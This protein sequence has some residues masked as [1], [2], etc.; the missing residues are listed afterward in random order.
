MGSAMSCP[1]ACSKVAPASGPWFLKI[2]MYL[3]R[4]S[5]FRSTMRSRY[6]QRTSSMR[7]S[8]RLASVA[9][10]SGVSMMTSCAP[11]P[12]I[13]S[14]MPS[15]CRL[16][17]PSIPSAGNLFGTTRTVQPCESREA[18]LGRYASTSEGVLFSL[19]GQ[20]GQ[21]PPFIFTGSRLKSLGRL[22]RSVEIM[23]HRPTIGSLRNSG[24]ANLGQTICYLTPPTPIAVKERKPRLMRPGLPFIPRLALCT[25]PLS[26]GCRLVV[27]F[28]AHQDDAL[29]Q[30]VH[31]DVGLFFRH[32]KR[33]R[34]SDAVRATTEE[35]DA[36]LERQLDDAVT[37]SAARRFGRLVGDDL[38]P[39]HQAAPADI[40]HQFEPLRPVSDALHNVLPDD[41]GILDALAFQ[42]VHGRHRGRDTYRITA[43]SR[44]VRTGHPVHDLGLRHHDA[45]RHA[46]GDSLGHA[47]DVGLDT[48][49]LNRPPFAR[50]PC[51]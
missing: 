33:R 40:T 31:C 51:A 6:A 37:F 14:N 49:V 24:T 36:T 13:L 50:A 18:P 20:K 12:F 22:A 28:L 45:K 43:K 21:K 19:P 42:Y 34:N 46:A 16:K 29:L 41:L 9:S 35:E 7:F 27:P 25:A 8:G 47:D 39:D 26:D 1:C 15:A 5:F 30:H 17:L 23:T 32:H 44:G 4:R 3:K 11:M 2:R 10:C 38:D 48:A